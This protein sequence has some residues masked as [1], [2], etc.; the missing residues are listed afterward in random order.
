M[1][2]VDHCMISNKHIYFMYKPSDGQLRSML[3]C[4]FVKLIIIVCCRTEKK[5]KIEI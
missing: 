5:G 4:T 1:H 2:T 3:L